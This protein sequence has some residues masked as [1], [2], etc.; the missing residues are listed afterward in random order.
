MCNDDFT[1]IENSKYY[2]IV[3]KHDM[4]KVIIS[5]RII[6]TEQTRTENNP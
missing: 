3:W 2:F 6:H 1:A 4:H 5:Q